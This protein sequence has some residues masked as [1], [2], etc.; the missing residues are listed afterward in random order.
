MILHLTIL[1]GTHAGHSVQVAAGTPRT[2]GRASQ[3]DVVLQ[4]VY[5]SDVHFALYCDDQG[6]RVRDLQSHNGT[7]LN[8]EPTTDAA[9]SSGDRITAGQT[10]FEVALTASALEAPTAAGTVGERELAGCFV[11]ANNAQA[12]AFLAEYY[13]LPAPDAAGRA[14]LRGCLVLSVHSPADARRSPA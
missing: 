4:D 7:F 11:A 10:L 3:S 14:C 8:N 9:L 1:N 2:F 5:L 6:A 13:D 12:L